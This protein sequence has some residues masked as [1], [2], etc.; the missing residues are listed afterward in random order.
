MK[1][2]N[3]F[4]IKKKKISYFHQLIH[5]LSL[6]Q[7]L[8]DRKKKS[9]HNRNVDQRRQIE[10]IQDFEMPGV[11]T[12]IHVSPDHQFILA[13]GTYKPRVKCY[14]FNNL[15]VKF[16]RCF[17]NEIEKFVIL[18]DDY[19]KMAFLSCDR[20][21]EFHTSAGGLYKLRIPRFG[22]DITYHQPSCDILV[23]AA[24]T[25]LY[26]LNLERGQFMQPFPTDFQNNC[27]VVNPEHYL[28]CVGNEKGHVESF[29][30]RM[31]RRC[32]VLDL[33]EGLP[34]VADFQV[35]YYQSDVWV[36]IFRVVVLR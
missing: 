8:S 26:R 5:P 19:S 22:R 17:D 2:A 6:P 9:L 10:L 30:H 34:D 4:N 21:V 13:T 28:I 15:S 35:S 32:G 31:K 18:S 7:W 3:I 27:V 36:F 29:D 20:H 14:E 1:R 16:E 11:A 25:E 23:A 24:S 12:S 33:H